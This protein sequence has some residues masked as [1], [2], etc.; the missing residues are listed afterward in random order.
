[1]RFKQLHNLHEQLRRE[2]GAPAVPTFPPKK[3]LSLTGGQL[4][5]RRLLLEKY[6]QSIGQD[7]ELVC[8]EL[9]RGFL[10]SAQHETSGNEAAVAV[11]LDVYLMN[12]SKVIVDIL[13]TDRSDQVLAKVCRQINLPAEY[14]GYF[15]LF[16]VHREE[17]VAGTAA[18]AVDHD[19]ILRKLQDFESPYISQRGA[20][21]GG[22][23]ARIIVRKSYWDAAYDVELMRNACALSLLY[24]Q[25]VSDMERGWITCA[26]DTR[27]QLTGLQARGAK[28][29]YLELARTLRHYG[30]VQFAECICDVPRPATR[31]RISIGQH[32]LSVMSCG[33]GEHHET[34]FRITRMRCWRITAV[35]N[36]NNNQEQQQNGTMRRASAHTPTQ[37]LELSFEYLVCKDRLRWVTIASDQAI[38][39]SVCLQSVVDELLLK[40]RGGPTRAAVAAPSRLHRTLHTYMRR[41]GSSH[42]ISQLLQ[43]TMP[44]N[45]SFSVRGLQKKFSSVSFKSE[46]EFVENHAFEG[47][48]D[49]DL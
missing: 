49:D 3:L 27:S 11:P 15:A 13:T 47:I 10:L 34:A 26:R 12:G 40:R 38:L 30:H 44:M 24:A 35:H 37:Q 25:T 22:Q 39:M 7:T 4:E 16:L 2:Y 42:L 43:P 41:D 8:S 20:L 45:N 48:G 17:A 32:E 19:L 14:I 31:A 1:M 21:G 29:D 5:E 46:R 23:S 6:I 33:E 9:V 18:V 28:R 36:N